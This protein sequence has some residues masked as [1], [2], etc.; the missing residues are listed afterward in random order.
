MSVHDT[1]SPKPGA[2]VKRRPGP[3]SP[4]DTAY[5]RAWWSLALYPIS[6]VLAFVIGEGMLS[7][8]AEDV[9]E[10]AFWEALVSVTPA[11]LVFVLPGV[12]AVVLGRKAMR[13]GRSDG[14]VPAV[15]G[16]VIGLGFA[17]L[18]VLAFVVGSLTG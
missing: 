17:A 7:L 10:P 8:L 1:A 18:N 13:L 3:A 2:H 4:A 12:L 11:L 16:A 15:V 5:R 14:R 6:F 9:A